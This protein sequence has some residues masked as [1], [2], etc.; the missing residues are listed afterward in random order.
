VQ[1]SSSLDWAQIGADI[2]GEA[3]GD[4]SG[5]SVAM[6]SDGSRVVVGGYRNDGVNGTDSGH[7]RIFDFDGSSWV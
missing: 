4:F 1:A 3:A 5:I 2:D 6:S 7:V